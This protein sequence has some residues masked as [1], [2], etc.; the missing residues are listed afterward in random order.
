MKNLAKLAFYVGDKVLEKHLN[1]CSFSW[2][3]K[4]SPGAVCATCSR[5][6]CSNHAF[7]SATVPPRV[8]CAACVLLQTPQLLDEDGA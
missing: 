6:V 8:V 5:F 1:K 3:N 2:C 4:I 7:F